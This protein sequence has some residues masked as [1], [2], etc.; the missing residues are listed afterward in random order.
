MGLK[1]EKMNILIPMAGLGRRFK[2][3]GYSLPK[4]LIDVHGKPMIE[5][6]IEGLN[7][8]GNYIFVVQEKHIERYHLDVTLRKIAPHCKIVTLDGLTEGQACSALLAEKHIDN[9]EELLIVNCDNYFL[10]EVDQFLDKTSHNDFDGMIFTFK[11]DSGNPGW[12]YA[13]VDDDGRVIRVAEKEAISDTALAGAFYW[14]RGSDFVKYTKSMIDKDVRINN[15]F[16]IT[17]TFNE[18]ISDGKI[19]C[20]YNILAMRS[21]DTPGDLKDFK[22]WLE[23]KKVSSKVEKFIATPR[24]KNKD[25]NM[26]KS[27]KMQNVLEEIRQ[28]KPIILVD[29]YDRE[30]EGDIVIAAEMCS[31]DNLVFTMNNARGLMCIPCAGSILDRL[32]IPPMVTDNTDKNETPFTVSV[33]ARDD[34]TTGMSVQDRL[35][36]LSVLLDLESSPDELTRPG[37]LFP[38]RAR[39]K[40]LRE[41]RGHTEGS[42][43]LMHLSGLQPMAMICEIMNDDG[44]M[45]KG[46]DLNKF[47]V[48]HGLSIISIEEV[49]EAA[50]NESL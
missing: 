11:D 24:L 5:R 35:K 14:R 45:A 26:L 3:V 29:E 22:K 2:E 38:L 21:M 42:I 50:Y 25:K 10:W 15:E 19:I 6:V 28:G 17:P 44:T 39:P 43:H 8:D 1:G 32:E 30:N 36:T 41:R 7:I 31:V 49:Y 48:D 13:Q 23:I 40:L 4:P 34:T 12:S 37:H 18:A 16:Y 47:A 9:N 46:G 33:D 27:R 20:D